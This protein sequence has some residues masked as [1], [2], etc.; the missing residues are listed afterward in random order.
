MLN[1]IKQNPQ[2]IFLQE[3]VQTIKEV[4]LTP[5]KLVDKNWG[6]NTKS[7]SVTYSVN[8]EFDKTNF[9][10]ETAIQFNTKRAKSELLI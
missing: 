6:V 1:F 4:K 2:Q 5:K 9:L 7:K 8:P 3:K 10:G